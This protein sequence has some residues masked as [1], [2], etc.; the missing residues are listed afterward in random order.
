[1]SSSWVYYPQ[2][3]VA[4]FSPPGSR[5]PSLL[6]FPPCWLAP[7]V[8]PWEEELSIK[9]GKPTGR[10]NWGRTWKEEQQ[11]C[12]SRKRKLSEI[13]FS[14]SVS[15]YIRMCIE[16]YEASLRECV[17]VCSYI[18]PMDFSYC[19]VDFCPCQH[20]SGFGVWES[21]LGRGGDEQPRDPSAPEALPWRQSDDVVLF[22]ALRHHVRCGTRWPRRSL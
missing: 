4:N 9:G 5:G 15:V 11:H 21:D 14:V 20:V 12:L 17:D 18:G 6:G 16:V 19:P 3:P 22:R 2:A 8:A 13:Q 10:P 1:M 7:T